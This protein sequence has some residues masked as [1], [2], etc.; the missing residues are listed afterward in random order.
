VVTLLPDFIYIPGVEGASNAQTA[1]LVLMHVI[2]AAVIV[3]MLTSQR[4][5]QSH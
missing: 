1:V 4:G 5:R 3:R 2:A